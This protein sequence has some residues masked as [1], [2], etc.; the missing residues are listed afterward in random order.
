MKIHDGDNHDD[1]N[2]DE[3]DDNNDAMIMI[4]MTMMMTEQQTTFGISAIM[5]IIVVIEIIFTMNM[6]NIRITTTPPLTSP[7]HPQHQQHHNK[8]NTYNHKM[9]TIS[10]SIV[11]TPPSSAFEYHRRDPTTSIFKSLRVLST[12][13]ASA[14]QHPSS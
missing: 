3:K 5:N 8:H 10:R 14:P 12:L 11:A 13:V 1:G 6:I 2:K 9:T 4:M 7:R